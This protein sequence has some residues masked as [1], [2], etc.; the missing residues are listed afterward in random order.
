MNHSATLEHIE[1][2][3]PV[4]DNLC[5]AHPIFMVQKLVRDFGYDAARFDGQSLWVHEDDCDV[6]V[7]PITAKGLEEQYQQDGDEDPE[8]YRRLGY[9]DRWENVQPFFTR[10]GALCWMARN[11]HNYGRGLR[12]YV[13]CAHDNPEWQ[14]VR[15]LL[16]PAKAKP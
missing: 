8:G 12:V 13:E 5:T 6:D 10:D 2:Q 9:Q 15:E 1:Q 3:L 11:L 14:A 4:Q 7:D 16:M